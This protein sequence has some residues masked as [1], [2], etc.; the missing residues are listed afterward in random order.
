MAI[1]MAMSIVGSGL[2]AR[3]LVESAAWNVVCE[4]ATVCWPLEPTHSRLL[5]C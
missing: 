3:A 2:L 4:R 5:E 1:A